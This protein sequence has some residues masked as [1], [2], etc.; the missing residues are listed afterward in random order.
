M[1][2]EKWK[3]LCNNQYLRKNRHLEFVVQVPKKLVEL[4]VPVLKIMRVIIRGLFTN[5][6][7]TTKSKNNEK[8][9]G[10]FIFLIYLIFLGDDYLKDEGKKAK[11][12]S[13]EVEKRKI[14]QVLIVKIEKK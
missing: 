8:D 1:C 10:I 4:N 12:D 7:R 2:W 3:L 14:L 6:T 13:P 11:K 9:D 5:F